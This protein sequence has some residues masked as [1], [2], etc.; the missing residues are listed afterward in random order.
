VDVEDFGFIL[1]SCRVDEIKKTI[2]CIATLP[3]E[4]LENRSRETWEHARCH[5]TQENFAREY[6]RMISEIMSQAW[7]QNRISSNVVSEIMSA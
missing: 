5:H 4:E 1:R 3:A 6:R 2:Q 7:T